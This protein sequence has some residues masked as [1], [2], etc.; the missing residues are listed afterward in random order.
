MESKSG[1]NWNLLQEEKKI[2]ISDHQIKNLLVKKTEQATMKRY[3]WREGE[4]TKEK[5]EFEKS[6]LCENLSSV[7]TASA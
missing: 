1:E 3:N 5:A 6:G 7:E 2:S 4:N